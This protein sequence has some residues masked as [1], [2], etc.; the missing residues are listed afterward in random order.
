MAATAPPRLWPV[1]CTLQPGSS[2]PYVSAIGLRACYAMP[3]AAIMRPVLQ[4]STRPRRCQYTFEPAAQAKFVPGMHFVPGTRF[5]ARGPYERERDQECGLR[6][7]PNHLA[8]SQCFRPKHLAVSQH[9][10]K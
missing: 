8:V 10:S 3:G 2:I 7:W 4:C 5:L 6:C 9:F 1:R